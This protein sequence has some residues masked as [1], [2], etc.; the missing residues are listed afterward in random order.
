MRLEQ[1]EDAIGWKSNLSARH[2]AP[3]ICDFHAGADL[4][5]WGAGVY[6][7]TQGPPYPYHPHCTCNK[8]IV[9]RL[10]KDK[11][12]KF[13]E[14]GAVRFV[15]KNRRIHRE[16]FGVSGSEQIENNPS[17]WARHLN[18]YNGQQDISSQLPK[19]YIKMVENYAG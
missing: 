1:D 19:K 17:E 9:Y 15:K 4:Y 13:N 14:K 10:K 6:P 7:K 8:T 5:G 3:D 11:P 16:L 12:A 2:P 18:N